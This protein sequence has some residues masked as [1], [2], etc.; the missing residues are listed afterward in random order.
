MTV[1]LL[2][3]AVPPPDA[4]DAHRTDDPVVAGH[5]TVLLQDLGLTDV[6]DA[7]AAGD[8][9]VAEVVRTE[10]LAGCTDPE[11]LVARQQAVTDA[12]ARPQV[13]RSLYALASEA[14]A[15][16]RSVYAGL[17]G[18]PTSSLQRSL[19][20]L[21]LVVD[22]L[23]RLG[24]LADGDGRAMTSVAFTR[25]MTDLRERFD[26]DLLTSMT[27]LL[28]GL[29]M[30]DGIVVGV[31]S[32]IT[33]RG[34]RHE[35]RAPPRR[36]SGLRRLLPSGRSTAAIRLDDRDDSA[37]NAVAEL[38]EQAVAEVA[39][40]LETATADLL[41]LLDDL[42]RQAAFYLGAITLDARLAA[43]GVP[44]CSPEVGDGDAVAQLRAVGLADAGL[45]LRA[46]TDVVGNDVDADG[47]PLVLVTGANQGGKSTFLRSLGLA[48]VMFQAGLFVAAD[49]FRST[50][51]GAVFTHVERDE[52]REL[53]S[54]RLD[55]ELEELSAIVDRL[56]PGDL[57][58]CN[59]S[60]GSTNEREGSLLAE[61]V[62]RALVDAGVRVV[63]VTHLHEL[64]RSLYRERAPTTRF[65]RA[66]RRD[67]GQRTFRL[68][69]GAPL[70]TSYGL[71]LY[72]RVFGSDGP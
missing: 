31:T 45:A 2:P 16:E 29:R 59:E 1:E 69:E 20:V 27:D 12:I 37:A 5:R 4:T 32:G 50:I 57:L 28:E 60:F 47:R 55:A 26:D 70:P 30:S 40:V 48:Q 46:G 8:D 21:D 19:D 25:S 51:A 66:E 13:V 64:A 44:R 52:D 9:I 68:R 7:M 14:I 43:L 39:A 34:V 42:R 65:L 49:A 11:V 41:A 61:E 56:R 38:R 67:D 15:Q 72:D 62:V 10:L 6:I 23:R 36:S 3:G 18:R 24:R 58:L 33:G 53:R 22:V 71:D 17:V 35:L 63:F 54:G